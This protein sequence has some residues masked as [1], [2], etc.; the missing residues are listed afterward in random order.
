MLMATL[1]INCRVVLIY[2][3][4]RLISHDQKVYEE[5]IFFKTSLCIK[6]IKHSF[7]KEQDQH[8][9]NLGDN[10]TFYQVN[11]ESCMRDFSLHLA[12]SFTFMNLRQQH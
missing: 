11:V 4:V 3:I 6:S 9:T 12:F 8:K 2:S 1:V 7:T 5:I 10:Q